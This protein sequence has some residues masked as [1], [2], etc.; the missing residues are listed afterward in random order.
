MAKRRKAA[1]KR[2]TKRSKKSGGDEGVIAAVV[3]VAIAIAMIAGYLYNQNKKTA[4]I[5]P[6]PLVTI[7]PA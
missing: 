3:I 2:K 5:E 4:W 6:A 7:A 1:K